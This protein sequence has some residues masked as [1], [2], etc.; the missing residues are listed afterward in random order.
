MLCPIKKGK[1]YFSL[2]SQI[3]M[4]NVDASLH[5]HAHLLPY[6]YMKYLYTYTNTHSYKP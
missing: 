3:L 2:S 4:Q 1:Y 5:F 6:V